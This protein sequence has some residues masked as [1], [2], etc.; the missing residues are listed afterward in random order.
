M[1][2]Q[3]VFLVGG[4]GTRLKDRTRNTPKP[5]LEVGGR[6]F[7][8]YLLDEAARHGFREI[9][10]LAGH[11]GDQVE[12][13]YDGRDWRGARIK[14]LREPEPLGTGGALRFAL[15]H[16]SDQFL[17]MNGDTFFGINLR[18]LP[19]PQDGV[20]MALRNVA[21]NRYGRATLKDD[22]IVGFHAPGENLDGP[23]NAGV[24]V[25]SRKVVE[26]LPEGKVAFET[27]SFP[28]LVA[29]GAMFGRIF[30]G[31]FIDIGVPDDFERAQTALPQWVRR[32]A[33]FF[34]RDGVL[35]HDIGYLHRPDQFEWLEGAKRAVRLCN[36]AGY[37]VFVVTNQA[38]VARGYY[39]ESD[40]L[41]LHT[42][43]NRE[44]AAEGAHIDAFEYCPHHPDGV[45]GPYRRPC[46][47][48]K[49]EPGMLLDLLANW[50]VDKQASFLVGNMQSDLDAAS[51][52]GL[53]AHLY[54]GGDLAAFVA[55]RLT[56]RPRS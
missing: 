36:D 30:D 46:H 25:F 45:D 26:A 50:P 34:D 27:E 29:R 18:A 16:L 33:V 54:Q 3:A 42:W 49:P 5:L 8:E 2:T 37:F 19:D 32:P 7:L 35:N 51:G 40:V 9:L 10:L 24:Y 56:G 44:L 43:I 11:F 13:L 55:A 23:I 52:A 39:G 4:L 1:L 28:Q 21:G 41:S 22:R 6:P 47:R 20:S 15:P 31:H 53:Q 48:R 17:L 38:G 14:V 12:A